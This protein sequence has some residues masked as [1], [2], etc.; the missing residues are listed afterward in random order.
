MTAAGWAELGAVV[1]LIAVGTRV[2]GPYL[3]GVYGEGRA[4]G[5]RVF[6]AG[7]GAVYRVCG[8]DEGRG[9]RW[10]IYAL[11]LLAFRMV[12]GLGL[13]LFGRGQGLRPVHPTPVGAV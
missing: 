8:V 7:G 1:V 11:A 2:V 13:Y 10:E 12:S 4:W 6:S 3:A 5:G 9:E